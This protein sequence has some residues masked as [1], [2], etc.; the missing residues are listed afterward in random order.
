MKGRLIKDKDNNVLFLCTNG[1]YVRAN[2]RLMESLLYDFRSIEEFYWKH[3]GF[4]SKGEHMDI[5][6]VEGET[7]AYISDSDQLVIINSEPFRILT[8][9]YQKELGIDKYISVTAFAN[10]YK[11]S[12]EIVKVLCREGRIPGATKDSSGTW[13][14]PADAPYP[15]PLRRQR[16]DRAGLRKQVRQTGMSIPYSQQKEVDLSYFEKDDSEPSNI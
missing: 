14:I 13:Q 2:Y 11:K 8:K 9:G 10:K 7:L 16:S 5:T 4:W 6:L 12:R 15:I 1:T 3:E